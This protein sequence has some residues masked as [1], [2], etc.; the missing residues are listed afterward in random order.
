MTEIWGSRK[1]FSHHPNE[2]IVTWLLQCW[3]N[4]ANSVL[5]DSREACQLGSIAKNSAIDRGISRCQDEAFTLWK[6]MLLAM[7]EKYPFKDDLMPEIKKW[8]TMEKGILYLKECTM[9]EMLQS[10]T[11]IPDDPNQKLDPDSQV[12][13]K[14]VV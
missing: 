4:G 7:K 13:T 1:D 2:H 8:T 10:S 11:F 5:L 12:Y 3:D 14:Y 6:Q 9:V